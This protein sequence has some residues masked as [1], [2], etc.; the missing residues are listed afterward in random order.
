[1]ARKATTVIGATALGLAAFCAGLVVAAT[2]PQPTSSFRVDDASW[3]STSSGS[4][5]APLPAERIHASGFELADG[6]TD[7]HAMGR[8][9]PHPLHDSCTREFHDRFH[10]VGPDGKR[11]PTWHPPVAYDAARRQACSFGHE[12]GRDPRTSQLW[13]T[14]QIQRAFH[15][16]ADADGHMDANE[17]ALAGIPFG[18]ANEQADFW[19][20]VND[21]P[22]MRHEDH[23]GHKIELANGEPDIATHTMSSAANGGVWVGRLGN[24]VVQQDTGMRCFYLAKAHQGTSTP[25]AFGHNLHEVVYLSDCRHVS[26]LQQCANPDDLASCADL[27]PQ[28]S[29]VT[30]STLQPFGRADG[31]TSFMPM[32]GIE[33]RNDP[34]DFVPVPPSAFSPWWPDGAGDR[35]IITRQC[36]EIGFL[37]PAGQWSG[38]F[39]EAWPASLALRRANG[40]AVLEGINL[41]FDV[42]DAA[43]YF[44]PEALKVERGY[45]LERPELAGTNLGYSM[46]LC[47]DETL[48]A[49]GRRARGGACD[50]ATNFGSWLDVDWDDP[51]SGFR[52]LNRGMYFQPPVIDNAGG[53]SVWYTDPFGGR[54]STM[55]FA[56]ALRQFVSTRDV[57][58]GALIGNSIDPRVAQRVHADGQGTVHA[59]N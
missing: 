20:A 37:V 52:G 27:H 26:D 43:R 29:R 19:F 12:H 4:K 56:G 32:C 51:R 10:V 21:L 42:Q 16:D 22:T 1:M 9:S 6:A 34:Q 41:L 14:R 15:W 31:F 50:T 53:A 55:P 36:A 33:R 47:Y 23:V 17:E 45:D 13:K 25:D 35:E 44:Y 40:T 2:W 5:A 30:V 8:W 3:C 54:A 57:D 28:N 18:Y 48:L 59:P 58:Y 11:Y 49:Q 24:G 46:D 38:N 7:S 39:Y